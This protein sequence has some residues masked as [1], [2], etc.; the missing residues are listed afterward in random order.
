MPSFPCGRPPG[1]PARRP[2]VAVRLAPHRGP[3]PRRPPVRG[4]V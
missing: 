2:P 1:P 3:R 4:I